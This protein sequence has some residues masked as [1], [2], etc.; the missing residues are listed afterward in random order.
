MLLRYNPE[1]SLD[2]RCEEELEVGFGQRNTRLV[3]PGRGSRDVRR[4]PR[5]QEKMGD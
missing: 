1:R 3:K 5:G 4:N 2:W